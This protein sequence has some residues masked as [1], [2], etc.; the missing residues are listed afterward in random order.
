M[1]PTG[2]LS[3][4]G[5]DALPERRY[6]F[7]PAINPV[8]AR[9]ARESRQ[10]EDDDDADAAAANSVATAAAIQAGVD[11]GSAR[12]TLASSHASPHA[13]LHDEAARQRARRRRSALG[14]KEDEKLDPNQFDYTIR[15]GLE[16][17]SGRLPPPPPVGPASLGCGLV[18]TSAELRQLEKGEYTFAPDRSKTAARKPHGLT[19]RASAADATVGRT[20][21]TTPNTLILL[22]DALA[23]SV[24]RVQEIFGSWDTDGNGLVSAR[25]FRQ[26]VLSLGFESAQ[27]AHIDQIFR[28]LDEDGSGSISYRE[29]DKRLRKYAGIAVTQRHE[30]RKR[31][32]AA[33]GAP[34]AYVPE[35][36]APVVANEVGDEWGRVAL[37]LRALDGHA[38]VAAELA[39]MQLGR[40]DWS[41]A[42]PLATAPAIE[43]ERPVWD[44][45]HRM[46]ET[47]SEAREQRQAMAEEVAAQQADRSKFHPHITP[48]SKK[49]H[50]EGFVEDRLIAGWADSLL[51]LEERAHA[52]AQAQAERLAAEAR[53]DLAPTSTS[54]ARRLVD[55]KL[56]GVPVHRRLYSE[57]ANTRERLEMKRQQL[58]E[59]EREHERWD[60]RV[61]PQGDLALTRRG[62]RRGSLART[63][64]KSLSPFRHDTPA[65]STQATAKRGEGHGDGDGDDDD[66]DDDDDGGTEEAGVDAEA[67]VDVRGADGTTPR[68]IKGSVSKRQGGKSIPNGPIAE[69]LQLPLALL[70]A[71]LSAVASAGDAPATA[72]APALATAPRLEPAHERLYKHGADAIA[73]TLQREQAWRKVV[74]ERHKGRSNADERQRT[75]DEEA[76]EAEACARLYQRAQELQQRQKEREAL[77][78]RP[79]EL[80]PAPPALP[81][82]AADAMAADAMAADANAAS[83]SL[84]GS[85]TAPETAP[86]L[87][88]TAPRLPETA[89]R[90][91][92]TAPRLPETAHAPRVVSAAEAAAKGAQ[93][94][95]EAMMRLQRREELV[96]HVRREEEQA[97]DALR[98]RTTGASPVK[99]AARTEHLYQCAVE[100][101]ARLERLTM[102]RQEQLRSVE[103]DGYTFAPQLVTES[104]RQQSTD[105]RPASER[106]LDWERQRQAR[107]AER[108]AKRS[109]SAGR[110]SPPRAR[111]SQI[112]P[113]R[114][115]P[116]DRARSSQS[117]PRASY[118]ARSPSYPGSPQS[119]GESPRAIARSG[120]ALARRSPEAST[121]GAWA[122]AHSY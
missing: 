25:E 13:R 55:E 118:P 54:R 41:A 106:L 78:D 19:P 111:S 35:A 79:Q 5:I 14:S 46:A 76:A 86:R 63:P 100:R 75:A 6:A 49:L 34:E 15:A 23:R 36:Y 69:G 53:A 65:R 50:R 80:P 22:R 81:A 93:R 3:A 40:V 60:G 114:P 16:K 10:R 121:P 7:T 103:L 115:P 117:P 1:S 67:G 119:P 92:E 91:P 94:H 57:A 42:S 97:A 59:E 95:F 84:A 29:L 30:L 87:P 99:G 26:A 56:A 113:D 12:G 105:G 9:L 70:Q 62:E 2:H 43:P 109:P 18:Y 98:Q 24:T 52:E 21:S 45:L 44:R 107:L 74:A 20:P 61:L 28:E 120:I 32:G 51:A 17:E 68:S 11:A 110:S 112:E 77:H 38:P 82:V 72:P 73:K 31:A 33:E 85:G 108:I 102:E 83:G 48:K 58:V 47:L 4:S 66:D 104:D 89:P 116:E 101:Q 39:T 122:A 96:L 90:L 71:S 37:A 64:A 88:E 27:P 8:S